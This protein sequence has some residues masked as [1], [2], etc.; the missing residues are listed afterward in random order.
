MFA[1][2]AD[3]GKQLAERLREVLGEQSDSDKV[4]VVGLPRGGVPVASQVATALGVPLDLILVRK[5]GVPGQPEVAMGSIGERGVRV[6]NRE[7]VR[8]A[9]VSPADFAEVEA[10]ERVELERRA[11]RYAAARTPASLEGK[12]VVIVD[13]GLATG[14]TAK[15]ACEVAR[16]GGA[17]RV[18]LAVP[19]APEGWEDHFVGVADRFVSLTTPRDFF[20]VGHAYRDFSQTSDEE[21]IARLGGRGS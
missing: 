9:Q 12:I 6:V 4:V 7:I 16:E 13:D 19:V 11:E 8:L 17:S 3:A 18:I 15:A 20:G 10:R 5:L 1:D 2:R 14:A 21:V